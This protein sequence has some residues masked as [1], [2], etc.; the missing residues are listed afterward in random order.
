MG[1]LLVILMSIACGCAIR[2]EVK[3]NQWLK[4]PEGEKWQSREDAGYNR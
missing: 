4:T 3:H 1:T 2:S